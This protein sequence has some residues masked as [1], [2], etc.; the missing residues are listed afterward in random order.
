MKAAGIPVWAGAED[1][2]A[3]KPHGRQPIYRGFRHGFTNHDSQ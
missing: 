2:Q 1:N 3:L